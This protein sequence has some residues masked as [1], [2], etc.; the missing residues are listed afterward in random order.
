[1]NKSLKLFFHIFETLLDAYAPLK[2]L[3]NSELK[4]NSKPWITHG[5]IT[6]IKIKYKIYKKLLKAKNLNK[7]G[8]Y[9][10]NS[11]DIETGQIFLLEILKQITTKTFEKQL[12]K[13]SCT[14]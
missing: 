12:I 10:T 13:L 2:K 14:Y 11:K 7:K 6:P 8:G 3:L 4:L 5:I 9:T 1:M